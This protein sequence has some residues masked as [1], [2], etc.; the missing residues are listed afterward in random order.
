MDQEIPADASTL[1]YLAK[2]DVFQQVAFLAPILCTPGVWRES[3]EQGRRVGATD[4]EAI[5]DA[6]RQGL[7]KRTGLDAA[8][9][10]KARRLATDK[11]LGVGESEVLAMVGGGEMVLLDEGRAT[12]VAMALGLTP[13]SALLVP[14]LGVWLG[15]LTI[16]EARNL[17]RLIAV[18]SSV[19]SATLLKIEL[20]LEDLK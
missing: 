19:K 4:V 12:R 15:H 1:I 17:V 5:E 18:P 8:I 6:E 11:A 10:R 7:I 3:V 14:I 20:V 2:A 9:A 16:L 13:I